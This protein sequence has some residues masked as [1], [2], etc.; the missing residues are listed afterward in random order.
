VPVPDLL[1]SPPPGPGPRGRL[2]EAA[3][4]RAAVSRTLAALALLTVAA[5]NQ[6][7]P[8]LL[9][10][11]EDPSELRPPQLR[12]AVAF[13]NGDA[14]VVTRPA[15]PGE[16]LAPGQTIRLLLP[17][18]AVG[19][20]VDVSVE[21]VQSGAVVGRANGR[22]PVSG[23]GEGE[24]RLALV[25]GATACSAA[26]CP[27]GCCVGDAC[28]TGT[29]EACGSGGAACEPCPGGRADTCVAGG[30]RCGPDAACAEG[31]ACV[32]GA[33]EADG[34]GPRC[35]RDEHCAAPPG[36]CFAANGE[37][38]D[39]GTCAYAPKPAAA[40][41]DDGNACTVGDA[42]NGAGTCASTPTVCDSPP[43]VCSAPEGTCNPATGACTYPSLPVGTSCNDGDTCS[44]GE[45]CDGSGA[46]S[47]GTPRSC[48]LPPSAC[49][50]PGTCHPSVG[51]IYPNR[52]DGHPCGEDGN[53]C[54]QRVCLNGAC[55]G[56]INPCGVDQSC[57]WSPGSPGYLCTASPP[58]GSYLCTAVP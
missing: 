53:P 30:C 55:A 21:A 56:S 1:R 42:C 9:L 10:T 58:G 33:C 41:C 44:V 29:A 54:S 50:A 8:S 14:T 35:T 25:G 5:C 48:E 12:V 52:L 17:D 18:D 3:P 24:I 47:G 43:G 6:T 28:I 45:T 40:G 13:A 23:A 37:C 49:Q 32:A 20:H 26:T 51:C 34:E 38:L 27:D 39:D 22:F 46:C 31:Y 15:E 4:H 2:P 19:G 7:V 11:V 36:Q 57:C 16:P